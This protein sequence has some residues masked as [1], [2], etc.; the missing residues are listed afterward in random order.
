MVYFQ[1]RAVSFKKGM[2]SLPVDGSEIL[3]WDILKKPIVD[4]A[5]LF[6]ISTG[7]QEF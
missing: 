1:G 4:S 7:W 2:L 5:I 3:T 6:T